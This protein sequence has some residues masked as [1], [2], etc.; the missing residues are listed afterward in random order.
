M[1]QMKSARVRH[2]NGSAVATDNRPKYRLSALCSAKRIRGHTLHCRS[3][4]RCVLQSTEGTE[5]ADTANESGG[6]I[7]GRSR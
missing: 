3:C 1:L 4:G 5:V 6:K 7:S 2:P